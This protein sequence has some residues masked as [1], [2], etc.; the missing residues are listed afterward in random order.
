MTTPK[1]LLIGASDSTKGLI[2]WVTTGHFVTVSE[3]GFTP[4]LIEKHGPLSLIIFGSPPEC[5]VIHTL[6]Q[7]QTPALILLHADD[8][9]QHEEIFNQEGADYLIQPFH[10]Q[11]LLFRLKKNA[12]PPSPSV[13][14]AVFDP[15]GLISQEIRT[16]WQ[17][18][19]MAVH[20]FNQDKPLIAFIKSANPD[21][22]I[23]DAAIPTHNAET[24]IDT[25][26]S[27]QIP[28]FSLFSEDTPHIESNVLYAQADDYSVAPF[29]GESLLL[30]LKRILKKKQP[31][32]PL[33]LKRMRK[34]TSQAEIHA[35][36]NGNTPNLMSQVNVTLNHEIR[37]PLTSI[38]IGAQVI[39]KRATTDSQEYQIAKE[40]EDASRRIQTTLDD[41][42]QVQHVVVDDYINGIK[43]LNLKRSRHPDA[44][45]T[46][47]C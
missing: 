16:K 36:Q 27:R 1:L 12:L 45:G 39:Q 18:L 46:K 32:T 15:S 21:L 30:R 35:A 25:V 26:K 38:L 7:H 22:V 41:F 43:M 37:S 14:A 20:L 44:T 4:S 8:L 47:P 42:G 34:D 33:K 19:G 23:T 2:E 6:Q 10:P 28:L 11:D 13:T 9:S 24:L 5:C 3:P 40:I 17:Q 29:G 31:L